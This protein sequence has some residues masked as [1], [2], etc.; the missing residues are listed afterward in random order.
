VRNDR[1]SKPLAKGILDGNLLDTFLSLPLP[2]QEEFTKQIGTDKETVIKEY[3][4]LQPV[5]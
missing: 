5:W 4:A 2:R 3:T 1:E